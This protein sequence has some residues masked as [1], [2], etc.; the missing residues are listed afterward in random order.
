MAQGGMVRPGEEEERVRTERKQ[1]DRGLGEGGGAPASLARQRLQLGSSG[2]CPP[3][4]KRTHEL[5]A[6]SFRQVLAWED[7]A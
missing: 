3:H 7:W 1:G 2:L 4:T 6:S 5:S